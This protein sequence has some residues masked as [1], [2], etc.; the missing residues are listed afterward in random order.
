[1]NNEVYEIMSLTNNG[2]DLDFQNLKRLNVYFD[3][4]KTEFPKEEE[5]HYAELLGKAR[6]GVFNTPW[7]HGVENMTM[8][9][10]GYIYWRGNH[11][12]HYSFD[13]LL[14]E[15]ESLL[16]LEKQCLILESKGF[17]VD[18][19]NVLCPY[20]KDAPKGTE[21]YRAIHYIYTIYVHESTKETWLIFNGKNGAAI[22][23]GRT[24]GNPLLQR[25]DFAGEMGCYD[26]FHA[27]QRQDGMTRPGDHERSYN[28]FLAVV[29][30]AGFKPEEI[31]AELDR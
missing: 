2:R 4:Y 11:I 28:R 31:Q 6:N 30:D 5:V 9:S 14:A 24:P 15:R 16:D 26:A 3:G 23:L 17:D 7:F 25:Q 18:A 21:W 20:L 8:D 13:D 29:N 22:S 10:Q 19:R 1:M 12:D 27:Y